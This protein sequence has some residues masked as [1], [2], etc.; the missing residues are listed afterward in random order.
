MPKTKRNPTVRVTSRKPRP[1]RTKGPAA[2]AGSSV[3]DPHALDVTQVGQPPADPILIPEIR[4]QEPA[5]DT[6]RSQSQGTQSY[7]SADAQ[8]NS[9]SL[10]QPTQPVMENTTQLSL[11]YHVDRATKQKIVNGEYVNLGS[12]LVRDPT[13]TQSSTLS[14]DAQGQLVA[15]PKQ[16][17]KISSVDNWTDAFLIF[18]SIY[19]EAHPNKTQ[20]MLKYMHDIRL[21]AEKA[22]G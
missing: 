5:T 12:L 20:Q 6:Q 11:G 9:S 15:H 19:L 18:S 8:F 22:N 4:T 7:I 16:T 17:H 21:G 10:S 13:K 3:D 14:V 1:K 2:A